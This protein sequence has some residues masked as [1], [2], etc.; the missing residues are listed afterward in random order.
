[1]T[2][3]VPRPLDDRERAM[4]VAMVERGTAS[5]EDVVVTPADRARWLA[6][7][8]A[9]WAGRSCGCGTC[10]S[11]EL[12]DA[13]GVTP[14]GEQSRVVLEG[15]LTGAL[16]LLLVDDDRPAHLELAPTGDTSFRRFPAASGL[17]T[18]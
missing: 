10:P 2:D 14:A 4:L 17:V 8:P 15:G 13:D 9:T 5:D 3:V 16:V 11:V 7:V 6:R 18:G 12:T 1:M